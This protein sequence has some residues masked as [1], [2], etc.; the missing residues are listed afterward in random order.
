MKIPT[1]PRYQKS[2]APGKI[3]IINVGGKALWI[4]VIYEKLFFYHT[5][6]SE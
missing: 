3:G 6:T 4:Y 5:C 2:P 1:V